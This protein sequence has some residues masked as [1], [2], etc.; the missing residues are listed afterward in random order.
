MFLATH[1]KEFKSPV[2]IGTVTL[3]S[4]AGAK[5]LIWVFVIPTALSELTKYQD[6]LI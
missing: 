4:I 3:M 1:E 5:I 6:F 2:P